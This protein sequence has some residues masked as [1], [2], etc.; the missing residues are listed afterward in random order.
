LRIEDIDRGRSRPE[1]E[2][3]IYEDLAWLG[4]EWEQPVRRQSDHFADHA[5]TLDRLKALGLIYPC[6]ATRREIIAAVAANGGRVE[7]DPDGAPLYPGLYRNTPAKV[8]RARIEAGEPH[9]LRLYMEAAAALAREKT[10][11]P[12]MIRNFD[13]DGRETLSEAH[14]ERWGDVVL[15]RK[16]APTSYHLAVV[17]DD[18][19]Q[20]VTH[21]T[22]GTDLLAA[23]DVHRLLQILLDLPGPVYCHHRLILGAEGRKL[24]KSNR[25]RS[26]R[27]LRAEGA[28]AEDIR[29]MVGLSTD[30]C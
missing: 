30:L 7:H 24:S 10:G 14:P 20:G 2:A 29:R 16:D 26:I 25:D 13:R 28:A 4:L 11:G 27:S 5:K 17:T 19:L 6:F 3:S 15:A 1:F 9:A 23:T 21:V 12:I 18:A 22:R 8:S